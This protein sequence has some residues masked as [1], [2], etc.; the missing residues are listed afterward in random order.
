MIKLE[1]GDFQDRQVARL[2]PIHII[3]QGIADVAS[4]ENAFRSICI[5]YFSHLAE[6]GKRV[7]LV[8]KSATKL[9]LTVESRKDLPHLLDQIDHIGEVKMEPHK[10]IVS[11][12]GEG[13]KKNR[14]VSWQIIKMLDEA[15]IE[16]ELI[17]QVASQI[18]FMFIID[19][20]NINQTVRL[21]HASYLE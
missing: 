11:I 10:A 9:T 2:H 21:L 17:S 5:R 4:N 1:A 15:G 6:H 7:Y 12:V 16:L 19:E 3:D 18:S 20:K 8:S 14:A 13:I